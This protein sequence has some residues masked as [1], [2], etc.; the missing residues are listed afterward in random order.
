LNCFPLLC[1]KSGVS[2]RPKA[3]RPSRMLR[4]GIINETRGI[5]RVVYDIS[6]KPPSTIEWE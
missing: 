5:N 6:S 3:S 4:F 2:G 1:R